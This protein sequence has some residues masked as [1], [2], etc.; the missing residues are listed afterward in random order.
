MSSYIK[1]IIFIVV[2]VLIST[3]IV[4]VESSTDDMNKSMHSISE[5]IV[6]GDSEYNEAVDLVN[7]KN[8]HDGMEKVESAGKSFN[9]SLDKLRQIQNSSQDINEIHR[10]YINVV[11]TEL[12]L[13]LQ[14]IDLFKEAIDCFEVQ[15][16]YT[17]SNYAYQANDLML[18]AKEYQ[19]QRDSIVA[20]NSNLF[21]EEFNI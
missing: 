3:A 9:N 19:N 18:Q 1:L 6:Q 21:K 16:N 20:N 4:F 11:I 10:E 7:S 14:A 2:L 8:F 12:E 15:S 13:K 17:G 5:G